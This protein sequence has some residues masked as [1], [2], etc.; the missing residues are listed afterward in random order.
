MGF[1]N[2]V[3]LLVIEKKFICFN[4]YNNKKIHQRLKDG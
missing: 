4:F 2:N 3:L 1:E